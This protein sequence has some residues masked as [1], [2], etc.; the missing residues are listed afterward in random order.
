MPTPFQIRELSEH[1]SLDAIT[2]L[3]HRAYAGLL[4]AGMNYTAASQDVETTARRC[5]L[6]TCL[7][8][9]SEGVVVGTV[10]FHDGSRSKHPAPIFR[11]GMIFFEQF[12]VEP[13]WQG[14]GVGRALFD[15]MLRRASALSALELGCDT[16]EPATDLIG[17]YERWGFRVERR[18][19]WP[20]KLYASVGLVRG[21]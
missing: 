14:R 5:A 4:A 1:D 17:M 15:E 21:V 11:P 8:A 13:A 9:V 2:A 16:A 7:V 6:G 20:G 10:T 18:F 3:L 19:Q 12:G